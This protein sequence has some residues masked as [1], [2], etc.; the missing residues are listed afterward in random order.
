MKILVGVLAVALTSSALAADWQ[1]VSTGTDGRVLSV[2]MGTLRKSGD[3]AQIW[4][5]IDYSKVK[6]VRARSSKELWK[7]NCSA[8]TV[9]IASWIDYAPDG[10]VIKSN[11]PVETSYEYEPVAP[12]TA[13]E[14]IMN[15]A[16]G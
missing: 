16:C 15:T 11:T 7:F 10:N 9:F 6:S 3:R 2:D 8:Q 14:K 13:G 1:I 5:Q 12:G 4:V